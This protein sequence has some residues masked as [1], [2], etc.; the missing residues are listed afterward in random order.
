MPGL[1]DGVAER[2]ILQVLD[3]ELPLLASEAAIEID[4]A[5]RREGCGFAATKQLAH[6]LRNSL[7]L[8][9]TNT[10]RSFMDLPT[11]AMVGKAMKDSEWTTGFTTLEQLAAE[12]WKV[13][14]NLGPEPKD[15]DNSLMK[16]RAFCVALARCASAYRQSVL[17]QGS[18]HPCR[19]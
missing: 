10:V 17:Q 2:P 6:L 7:E 4:C 3:A 11:T 1:S 8:T 12:A 9:E 18:S 5:I 15:E 13:A 16:L 19:K 14:D